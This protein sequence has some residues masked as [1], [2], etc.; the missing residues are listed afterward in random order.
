MAEDPAL[1]I[2]TGYHSLR[3]VD[4][5]TGETVTVFLAV[6]KAK[7]IAKMGD[8]RVMELARTV[9]EALTDY[10]TAFEWKRDGKVR[11]LCFVHLPARRFVGKYGAEAPPQPN[12]V[13]VAFVT[14]RWI[15]HEWRWEDA[16][17]GDPSI[18]ADHG[19]DRFGERLT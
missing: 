19:A 13:F 12:R 2:K 18:P 11:G 8:W 5:R 10:Q 1:E 17:P 6:P 7:A 14:E 3:G 16:D 15:L 9:P 4:P